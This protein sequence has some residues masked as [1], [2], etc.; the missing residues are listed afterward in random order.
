M[1]MPSLLKQRS[2][3][4]LLIGEWWRLR[5]GHTQPIPVWRDRWWLVWGKRCCQGL[6]RLRSFT[7][8]CLA[9]PHSAL[10]HYRSLKRC[11]LQAAKWITV[12]A[13]SFGDRC[14]VFLISQRISQDSTPSIRVHGVVSLVTHHFQSLPSVR[15]VLHAF[16]TDL[17]SVQDARTQQKPAGAMKRNCIGCS[18]SFAIKCHSI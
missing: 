12:E 10:M 1:L 11:G 3:D 18:H 16:Q 13:E 17:R 6:M 2:H 8:I 14:T 9:L 7:W 4:R 5:G 15:H